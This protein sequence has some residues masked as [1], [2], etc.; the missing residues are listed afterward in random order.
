[1]DF[2][3]MTLLLRECISITDG[4]HGRKFAKVRYRTREDKPNISLAFNETSKQEHE[5]GNFPK[6]VCQTTR[7]CLSPDNPR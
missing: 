4:G 3:R 1:M 5:Q 6:V 7:V 2:D